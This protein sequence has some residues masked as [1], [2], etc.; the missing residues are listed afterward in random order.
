M[1]NKVCYSFMREIVLQIRL[2]D[3]LFGDERFSMRVALNELSYR[4][5]VFQ[6]IVRCWI[7]IYCVQ[8]YLLRWF[9]ID[10]S[11]IFNI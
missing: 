8:L 3:R 6:Y 1:A 4:F 7:I 5:A 11:R 9:V 2:S 10:S